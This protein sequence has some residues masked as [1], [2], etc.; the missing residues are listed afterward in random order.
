ME[1]HKIIDQSLINLLV[2]FKDQGGCIDFFLYKGK[3]DQKKDD[4]SHFAVAKRSL[5]EVNKSLIFDDQPENNTEIAPNKFEEFAS[6]GKQIT[7][8][9]FLGAYFDFETKKPLIRGVKSNE[10]MN[11]YFFY[12]QE[13]IVQNTIDIQTRMEE[14]QT[15]YPENSN[16]FAY[17]FLEPPYSFGRNKTI[18]E[19]GQFFLNA[20]DILFSDIDQIE[21][22]TWST[23][24]SPYF[25]A[26]KEWWGTFFYTIYNPIKDIYVVVLAST[27][28]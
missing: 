13:E 11:S 1:K 16:G 20:I 9:E 6:S 3:D 27:T 23:N 10:T 26:G 8:K 22:Y 25:E 24:C 4:Q 17:A 14:Y 12:D 2:E 5:E 19:K 15:K 18:Q 7:G 21:V 28:D